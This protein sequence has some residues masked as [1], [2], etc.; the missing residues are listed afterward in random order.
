MVLTTEDIVAFKAYGITVIISNCDKSAAKDKTLP[1]NSYLLTCENEGGP[2]Y[3]IVMGSRFD[4]FD[5][6]YDRFGG[7]IKRMEWTDG[8]VNP[9]LWG[10]KPKEEKKRK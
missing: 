1:S 5:A 3:D 8:R 10:N 2:W 7:V 9:K 6:Y 4:I